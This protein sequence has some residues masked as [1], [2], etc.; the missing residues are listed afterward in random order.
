MCNLAPGI[1]NKQSHPQYESVALPVIFSQR[2]LIAN[3]TAAAFRATSRCWI[4]KVWICHVMWVRVTCSR[5]SVRIGSGKAH[6]VWQFLISNCCIRGKKGPE[7][8]VNQQITSLDGGICKSVCVCICVYQSVHRL[9]VSVSLCTFPTLCYLLLESNIAPSATLHNCTLRFTCWLS[10]RHLECLQLHR[11]LSVCVCVWCTR[12][13]TSATATVS[14]PSPLA[15]CL[16]VW[17]QQS[18][19]PHG[20]CPTS[21]CSRSSVP[22]ESLIRGERSSNRVGWCLRGS[23]TA[24]GF[25][26]SWG[27]YSPK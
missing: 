2:F 4:P 26:F 18:L 16:S 1:S 5:C 7:C 10:D 11:P 21:F 22:E 27:L 14:S 3:Y 20:S 17:L 6:E 9:Y 15:C 8:P 19:P 12:S 24:S 23:W 25:F 13:S